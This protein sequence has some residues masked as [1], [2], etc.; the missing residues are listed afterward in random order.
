MSEKRPPRS[1]RKPTIWVH[2]QR[3][4]DRN[5]R[6]FSVSDN[7]GALRI[8]VGRV[9]L[10]ESSRSNPVAGSDHQFFR[11]RIS[12]RAPP[13]KA[14]VSEYM[15]PAERHKHQVFPRAVRIGFD[16]DKAA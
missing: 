10:P 7:D 6:A 14:R 8:K 5:V 13:T 9:Y 15:V 11:A 1:E 4:P 2:S 16:E 3:A 12:P